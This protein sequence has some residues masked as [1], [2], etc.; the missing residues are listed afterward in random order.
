MSIRH[1]FSPFLLFL[2]LLV[3]CKTT[4]VHLYTLAPPPTAFTAIEVADAHETFVIDEV[5]VPTGVDRKQLILRG[6]GSEYVILENHQWTAPLREEVRHALTAYIELAAG[7]NRNTLP[8]PM[9]SIEVRI[10]EW[11]ATTQAVFLRAE[12]R[13]RRA[14]AIPPL[15]VR[16]ISAFSEPTSGTPMDLIRADGV[17]MRALAQPIARALQA[18]PLAGCGV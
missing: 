13:L 5:S 10:V 18:M 9:T 14:T 17:L 11:E 7:T 16:C 1:R 8:V 4:T 6:A 15:E 3:G 12:W 2:T